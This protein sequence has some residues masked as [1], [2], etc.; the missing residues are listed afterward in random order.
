MQTTDI[1]RFAVIGAGAVGCYFGGMLARAGHVVSLVGRGAHVQAMQREGLLLDTLQFSEHVPV[2]A[3][4]D[5]AA[6]AD[7]ELVL[8]CVKSN[9]TEAAATGI[10][11]HLAPDTLVLSL[12]NGVD[13]AQRLAASLVQPVLPA[14]VYVAV[15]MVAPG[16]VKHRGRGELVLPAGAPGERASTGRPSAKRSMSSANATAVA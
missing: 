9:D 2:Y 14:V 8:L 5:T 10:A 7:S 13:N 4:T 12:Q 16:H 1:P 15:E 3:S 11:P 6:I